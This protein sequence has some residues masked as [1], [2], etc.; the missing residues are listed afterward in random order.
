MRYEREPHPFEIEEPFYAFGSGMDIAIGA[1]AMG[2]NAIKAVEIASRYSSHCG[3]G[4]DTLT[5]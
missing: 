1:L 5:F 2:A 4:I 3:N